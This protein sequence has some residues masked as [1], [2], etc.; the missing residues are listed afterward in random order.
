MPKKEKIL[1]LKRCKSGNTATRNFKYPAKGKIAEAPDWKATPDC[2]NGLHGWTEN[3]WSYYD[4]S[5]KGNWVVLEANKADGFVEMGDKVKFRKGKVLYNGKSFE[6]AKELMLKQQPHMTFHQDSQTAGDTSTQKA[7]NYSTQTAGCCSTQT[8]GD[9]SAQKAGYCSTQTAGYCSTQTAGDESAQKAGDN[10]TQKA[11]HRS[12]QTAGDGSTQTAGDGST[13]T[14]G[15]CST[16]KA[17][18]KSTQ[19]AG[20]GSTQTAGDCSTITAYVADHQIN[21]IRPGKNSAVI[22]INWQAGTTKSF[23]SDTN[24][25]T[26]LLDGTCEVVR[27]YRGTPDNVTSLLPNEILVFG[28]NLNGNHAGGLARVCAK[29]FGAEEGIGEGV[30]GQSYAFPTLDE[31]MGQVSQEALQVSAQRLIDFANQNRQKIILLTK[32]G[33]GIAGFDE[34]EIKE[35]FREAPANIIKPKE[36]YA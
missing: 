16:Q 9:E 26:Y 28:S 34:D 31:A 15:Y 29:Q 33:C 11:G 7:G 12:T 20:R 24:F 22:A 30:T 2:G 21:T 4:H 6:K 5:L 25:T 35:H 3:N 8:A 18:Y 1:V 14:A 27:T 13:Q 32:V 19:T 17:E 10:S 23:V 36:W